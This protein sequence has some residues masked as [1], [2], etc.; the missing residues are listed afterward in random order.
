[1]RIYQ[2]EVKYRL[3]KSGEPASIYEPGDAGDYVKDVFQANPVQETFVV[4]TM[5]PMAFPIA[6]HIVAA[7]PGEGCLVSVRDVLRVAI[8]D[9]ATLFCVI[10][11]HPQL[12]VAEPSPADR[13]AAQILVIASLTVRI[14]LFDFIIVTNETIERRVSGYSFRKAGWPGIQDGFGKPYMGGIDPL[15]PPQI[16]HVPA[17]RGYT[18]PDFSKLTGALALQDPGPIRLK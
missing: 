13:Q 11:N 3:I 4:I 18:T 10:H 12:A 1:M 6:R 17:A 5:N 2:A 16:A 7:G 9:H 14:P 15:A 8:L